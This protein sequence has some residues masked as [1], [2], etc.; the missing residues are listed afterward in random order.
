[1]TPRAAQSKANAIARD[2]AHLSPF[3]AV[4][5]DDG[6]TVSIVFTILPAEDNPWF[7]A[8]TCDAA[9]ASSRLVQDMLDGWRM[10]V[11]MQIAD[12][13]PS[14]VVMA[15]MQKFGADKVL[16]AMRVGSY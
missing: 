11:L 14:P 1:M 16:G 5:A 12:G 6:S 2:L 9:V 4:G 7:K 15:A 8:V 3:S 10:S 13:D